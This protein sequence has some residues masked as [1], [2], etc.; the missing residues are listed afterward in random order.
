MD[1]GPLWDDCGV[2]GGPLWDDRH[3]DWTGLKLVFPEREDLAGWMWMHAWRCEAT[4][5][6]VHFYKHHATRRYLPLDRLGRPYLEDERGRPQP[7]PAGGFAL[8]HL[9]ADIYEPLEFELPR[10]VAIPPALRP[11]SPH[12]EAVEA[13][14]GVAGGRST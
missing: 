2:D 11:P 9:V 12:A 10:V 8:L 1:E 6:V 4:G 3:I 13:G 5:E 7:F 14:D